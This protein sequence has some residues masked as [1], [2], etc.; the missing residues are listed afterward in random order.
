MRWIRVLP[1]ILIGGLAAVVSHA[2]ENLL[3]QPPDANTTVLSD[4]TCFLNRTISEP[5]DKAGIY[6]QIVAEDFQLFGPDVIEK[7]IVWGGP[8]APVKSEPMNSFTV[9]IY[10]SDEILPSAPAR[11]NSS[12]RLRTDPRVRTCCWRWSYLA[13]SLRWRAS[14]RLCGRLTWG[15]APGTSPCT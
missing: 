5:D 9:T 8:V 15:P 4:I 1:L 12:K 11:G 13:S 10:E 7:I 3:Y 14:K 2:T 6:G